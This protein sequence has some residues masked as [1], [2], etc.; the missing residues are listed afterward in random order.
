[1]DNNKKEQIHTSKSIG[2]VVEELS[3]GS[4]GASS[5]SASAKGKLILQSDPTSHKLDQNF[6]TQAQ[7]PEEEVM[8]YD[9]KLRVNINKF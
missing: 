4:H 5:S 7:S 3:H 2:E 6:V 8:R 1:M 9:L